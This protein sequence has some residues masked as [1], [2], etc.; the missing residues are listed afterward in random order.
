[1]EIGQIVRPYLNMQKPPECPTGSRHRKCVNPTCMLPV[2]AGEPFQESMPMTLFFAR[3]LL[4]V[5]NR[6]KPQDR[7]HQEDAEQIAQKDSECCENS[8]VTDCGNPRKDE[9]RK[10]SH[11]RGG[12]NENRR[13]GK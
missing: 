6:Q 12:R 5:R 8:Q 13:M 9:C 1:M 11:R 2:E 10:A 7:R 4:A 3:Q